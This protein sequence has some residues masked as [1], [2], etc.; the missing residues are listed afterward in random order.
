M[1][2]PMRDWGLVKPAE[3]DE[4]VVIS[5]HLDDAVLGC[6]QLMSRYPGTTVVTVF[7]GRPDAYPDPMT[8]WD[9]KAGF[10]VGDDVIAARRAED[11]KAL[12]ELEARPVWLDQIEHQYLPKPEWVQADRVVD[13]LEAAV[14]A[15]RPTAVFAPFGLANPDHAVTHEASLAVRERFAE[16][17][18]FCYEDHGYKHIP[19]LLAWR[20]SQLFRAECWPTPAAPPVDAGQERKQA[21]VAHYTS[22]LLALE[23]DWALTPKLAAPAPEQYWRLAPPP[24]GWERLSRGG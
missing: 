13:G 2:L 9:T 6:S 23:A 20:V 24:E 8:D 10:S 18:W 17:A 16:P 14:R 4:I 7:A 12:A 5:P 19:G 22:Q 21:A 1:A 11:V 3:L 15:A